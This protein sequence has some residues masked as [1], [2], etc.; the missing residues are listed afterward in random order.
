M[1]K[2]EVHDYCVQWVEKKVTYIQQLIAELKNGAESDSK[3]SAGD[4]HETARAMMQLEQEKLMKQLQ[5]M[6]MNKDFLQ[7]M[8]TNEK[9]QVVK[10]GS[11]VKTDSSIFYVSVALGNLEYN[12]QQIVV[13][14]S[15]API[16]QSMKGLRIGDTFSYNK[17][18]YTIRHIE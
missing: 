14:S 9:S 18:T 6:L 16:I 10:S 5:M 4:K 15:T 1:T 11:L 13:L 7:R 12:Q 17:M 2:K 8:N 3:S